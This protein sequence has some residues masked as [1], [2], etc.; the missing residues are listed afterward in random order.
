MP[1]FPPILFARHPDSDAKIF[2]DAETERYQ[3][4]LLLPELNGVQGQKKLKDAK[5]LVIG[6]G[7]L[8]SPILL[9]LAAVGVGNIGICDDD[10]VDLSNLQRQVIY[11]TADIGLSKAKKAK[12]AMLAL[13]PNIQVE[14]HP[15]IAD[16][17]AMPLIPNYDLV[18]DGTDNFTA[19][20]VISDACRVLDK[21]H[22]YGSIYRFDGQM[23]VFHASCGPCYRCLFPSLPK[24]SLAPNCSEAGVLGVLPGIIGM[25]QA[26]E[27]LKLILKIGKP[28]I[29]RLL[30]YDALTAEMYG[31]RL[32]KREG[33]VCF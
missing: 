5:V 29:G 16:H 1:N 26:Q 24:K 4:H 3:R 9:Y 7:G 23:S 31:V 18:V 22:I 11:K 15:R 21:P 30:N 8:G 6:A 12:E 33:C 32:S 20:Y 27:T 13:N 2:S 28:L 10:E 19:R 17:N 14:V 25:L